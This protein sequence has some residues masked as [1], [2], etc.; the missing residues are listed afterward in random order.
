MD[1]NEKM[2]GYSI[3]KISDLPFLSFLSVCCFLNREWWNVC[4]WNGCETSCGPLD[5]DH[6]TTFPTFSTSELSK[7]RH[8][9]CVGF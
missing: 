2:L 8:K 9:I 7:K 5:L 3:V 6:E 1:D 4:E